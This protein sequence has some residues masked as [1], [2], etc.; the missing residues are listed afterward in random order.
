MKIKTTE[1][2]LLTLMLLTLSL[3]ACSDDSGETLSLPADAHSN[4]QI[5]AQ[6]VAT[7]LRLKEQA[8][9]GNLS[10]QIFDTET[11]LLQRG[12]KK[13]GQP[14]N[15]P[16]DR[17]AFFGDLHVHTTY[18]FDGYAFGTLAT[19]YDAYR[20]AKGESISNPAG[21]AMQL[22]RPL[23]FYA[24]TDHAMFL[25]VV[26]AAADTSTAFSKNPFSKPYHDLN[27]PENM[28]TG[29]FDVLK[30]LTTFS[31]FLPE[32]VTQ[33]LSG[34]LDREEVMDVVR[35]AWRDS[36]DAADQHY[37]PGQFTTFAAYEYTSSTA[38]MGNLHRNVV[39]KGTEKLPREP[40]SRFHSV[41]PEDLWQWMD[42]LREKGVESLAIPHNSNGSNGQM[43][44]LVDWAGNPMDD[45][46]TKQRV[47]NEPIVEITQIKGTSETHPILSSRDEWASFE[48]MPYRV[49][50]NALSQPRGSYVREA[51][52][53]G[54]AL[55]QQGMTNPYQF[56]FIGSSDTHS[57]ASQ[58]VESNFVSK[59]GLLSGT[60]E[61]R[62]SVPQAGI[63]GEIS[64][65]SDKVLN[66]IRG[67]ANLRLKIDGEVYTAGA[68]PTFGASG[69]AAAWAEENTR[70]S[71]Y[72]AFRRKEVFATSGPRMQI[73]L[74]AGYGFD[75]NMLTQADGIE[76]AY[77]T[78]VTMGGNL[79]PN[80]TAEVDHSSEPSF[81]VMASADT[82]S[83][84]LQRLQIIKGWVDVDGAH[85][86]VIDVACAGGASPVAHR[87]P[88]NGA[89][90]D[91][92]NCAINRETG[93]GQL[94]A[95]WRDPAFDQ[96]QRAFYYARVIENPTCRWST[97]DANR[98]GVAP[99][100]DLPMTIQERAWSS[101][102][103]YLPR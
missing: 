64:Y 81:L 53:N 32:A 93:A 89:K 40:F 95:L 47:R 37:V 12:V 72:S 65:L 25:G 4:P 79:L 31:S 29:T 20:F 49:A 74:F 78:G 16:A 34:Q 42:E 71:L 30:R 82:E 17:K 88:D 76:R 63:A 27:A 22:S 54:L 51:L 19:P 23:D 85:E 67:R 15:K 45:D 39:F 61:R 102:I 10:A 70:E 26:E 59:L 84:P 103:H 101:P 86:E 91:I 57:A 99:R 6:T 38:D 77:A 60:G 33:I 55:E 58:N 13:T 52:L 98:E 9:E 68:T 66:G 69:V 48:I 7:D 87:C 96:G 24:V 21:F 44:K 83:A 97:W 75:E 56:G 41:N 18:S 35:T 46:Y 100:P 5:L 43:F 3:I 11:E 80:E 8:R 90:V 73:R 62:G 94:S 50:T 14:V 1:L 2:K 92:R 36:I 28:G